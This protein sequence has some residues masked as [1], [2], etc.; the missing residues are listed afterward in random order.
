MPESTYRITG[1]ARPARRPLA[2]RA[3]P[4]LLG[5][6]A[7]GAALALA[8]CANTGSSGGSTAAP[9]KSFGVNA[10]GTVHFWARQATDGPAKARMAG[11]NA[12]H[13]HLHV[14]LHLTLPN[15]AVT[16]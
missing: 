16:E 2:A 5:I 1:A 6:M 4:Q 10:T 11:F 15:E 3:R 7:V 13:P 9:P 8:A 14:V 12:T